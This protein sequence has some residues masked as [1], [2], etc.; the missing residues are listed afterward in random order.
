VS[1]KGVTDGQQ[2]EITSITSRVLNLE[3]ALKQIDSNVKQSAKDIESTKS[4][5]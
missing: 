3:T 4:S 1:E 5:L 2:N